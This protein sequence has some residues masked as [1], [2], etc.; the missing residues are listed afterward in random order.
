MTAGITSTIDVATFKTREFSQ[1]IGGN[2]VPGASTQVVVDPATGEGFAAAPVADADQVNTA[3]EAAAVA[4][5]QWQHTTM[6]ER[7]EV[8]L[9]I[10]DAIEARR[11]EL[12]TVIT[13]ETG[14][15]IDAARGDVDLALIWARDTATVRVDVEIR[16]DDSESLVELRYRPLGVVAAIVPWN[17]PFFQT[18]Y[19]LAPAL[20]A[21]NVVVIKPSPTTPLNACLLAEIV[22]P[23]V[24]AGVVSV[25]GD[26]GEVGPLLT[27]HP[28]VAEVSF[29][30]STAAGRKVM[31]AGAET[32]KKVVLELGGNDAAIVLD[33]ADVKKVAKGVFDW[34]FMNTG[35]VCINIKR[36]F[37]PDSLYD[38]FVDEFAAL[39]ER[40]QVGP[41]IDPNTQFGPIQNARQ[42]E[43][44]KSYLETARRDGK[45]VAGGEVVDGPGYFV[46]P[47]VVCD[48]EDDSALVRE[49]TFGP[50]RPLLRYADL[51][52]AI[53][54]ANDTAYGLGNSVWG[55]DIER[56]TE[57]AGRLDSGTV[58]VNTHFALS[59]DVPFGGWKASG[60]GAEF[61]REGILEFMRLQVVNVNRA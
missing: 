49:E 32:L 15:P 61:G 36:I 44:V 59:P 11:E 9:R 27:A 21:G 22:A 18:L 14:K 55:T 48:I 33:D 41:G 37:V 2:L 50:I 6:G 23:L 56:A 4:F 38:E 52:D 42:F 57:V 20:L 60:I 1:L 7:A 54:R 46:R 40:A 39:A 3:V 16:R 34:A 51:E 30:G 53:A 5:E 35:Q 45:I 12:A 31:A 17:F 24:P 43:T 10:A 13:L 26:S 19:K 47:T 8:V 25:L 29:T 28:A 58:W